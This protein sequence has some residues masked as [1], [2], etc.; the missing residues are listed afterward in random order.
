[1]I[2]AP[3]VGSVGERRFVVLLRVDDDVLD[4]PDRGPLREPGR[5]LIHGLGGDELRSSE[6]LDK[7]W[8]TF[9]QKPILEKFGFALLLRGKP[10]LDM[11]ENPQ[12]D[13]TAVIEFGTLLPISNRSGIRKL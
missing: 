4:A 8:E 5:D 6:L 2:L 7:L 12:Q 13:V 11:E 1:M 3:G 9:E 10:P